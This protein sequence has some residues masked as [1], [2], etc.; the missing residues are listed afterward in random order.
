MKV[1]ADCGTW[2]D[3]EETECLAC[4]ST[5]LIHKCPRCSAVFDGEYCVKCGYSAL[6]LNFELSDNSSEEKIDKFLGKEKKHTTLPLMLSLAG[7][8]T[9]IFPFSI[10]AIVLAVKELRRGNSSPEIIGALAAAT[11]NFVVLIIF[12]AEYAKYFI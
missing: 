3:E 9:C 4:G 11:M 5:N 12:F 10:A 7:L 8:L 1:C 6:T 2:C